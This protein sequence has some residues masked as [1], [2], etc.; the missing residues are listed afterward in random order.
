MP[1][2]SWSEYV[3]A[4]RVEEVTYALIDVE[5]HEGSV[6]QGMKLETHRDTFPVFQYEL[7]GTWKDARSSATNW[8]QA[9]LAAYLSAELSAILHRPHAPSRHNQ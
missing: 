4:E 5:G 7:G 6:I 3:A 8:T 9:D 1:V 2:V